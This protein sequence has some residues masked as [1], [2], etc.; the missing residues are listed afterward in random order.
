MA[1][2]HRTPAQRAATKRMLAANRSR[3][4]HHNP[5]HKPRK[6]ARRRTYTAA[7]RHHRRRVHRNP[8]LFGRGIL[9]ELASKDG[10]MLL[11]A[12]AVA[13]TAVD[14]IAE[15]VVPIQYASG[16]T[17]L[18]AKAAIAAASAY[19]LDRF[20]NRKAAIGFAVGSGGSL[21]ALAYKTFMVKQA[22]PA[23]VPAQA[24]GAMADEIAKN[25]SL[26]KSL[27]ESNDWSS[28]NGYAV[29][30][31]GGYAEAPVGDSWESLN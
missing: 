22:L 9:G 7:P 1:K 14:F 6:A 31:M 24:T 27:M 17:G 12:A 11:G 19:A 8:S 23:T 26:Y 10:L 21:L 16:M 3:K 30:P 29:A 18:L 2:R 15:K 13:P 20:V 5:S 4:R 28:L 25:P